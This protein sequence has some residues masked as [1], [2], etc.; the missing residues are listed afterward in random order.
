MKVVVTGCDG[1]LGWH[2]R[3]RLDA[4]TDHVVIPVGRAQWA[5]LVR[6]CDDS[7]ALIHCAGVN[8]GAPDVVEDDNVRL[9]EA[10]ADVMRRPRG[11]KRVVYANSIHASS[12]S[13]YGRGK[14]RAGDLLRQTAAQTGGDFVDVVLPNLFGEHGKPNYNSFVATFV[15]DVIQHR[16][17]ELVD[18]TMHLLHVQSAAQSL[19][20]GVASDQRRFSPAG[21]EISV[22]DVLDKLRTLW[23]A[24]AAGDLPSL[25]DPLELD[26]FNTLR[27]ALFPWHYPVALIV[28]ADRRGRLVETVRS[29]GGQG[30]TFLSSTR[31]GVTRGEHYHLHKVE[32]FVV[33][34]GRARI[35]VRRLFHGEIATFDVDGSQPVVVDMPTMWAHDITN[36]GEDELITM[37]WTNAIFDPGA[38]DT[39]PAAVIPGESPGLSNE[40]AAERQDR[41]SSGRQ[42]V[43][44]RAAP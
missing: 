16:P 22:R 31:P 27:A 44:D 43:G 38:P 29:R 7:D 10:V 37:F 19:I 20:D 33:V 42:S 25:E 5:D 11:P 15:R 23:T 28:H 40:S 34:A 24:Y 13:P 39:F 18:R 36:T 17:P 35:R 21:V 4:T 26:L 8:R 12:A 9:A 32:R 6:L 14:Q 41:S 3:V 30:Q 1:F 2:T